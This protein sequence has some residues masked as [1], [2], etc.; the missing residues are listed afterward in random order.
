[1][2]NE[3]EVKLSL[4]HTYLLFEASHEPL[5]VGQIIP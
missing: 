2:M 5:A 1:M 3:R 4:K